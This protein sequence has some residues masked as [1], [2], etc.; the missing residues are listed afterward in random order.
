MKKIL[1]ILI[2]AMLSTNVVNASDVNKNQVI[3]SI[4]NAIVINDSNK[5]IR[6]KWK[7]EFN[8]TDGLLLEVKKLVTMMGYSFKL[9]KE[10]NVI[11]INIDPLSCINDHI[12]VLRGDKEDVKKE[13]DKDNKDKDNVEDEEE[14]K[15][16]N[17]E[18]S[19]DQNKDVTQKVTPVAVEIDIKPEHF[20]QL[21]S[22]PYTLDEITEDLKFAAEHYSLYY[23][24][25]S[26]RLYI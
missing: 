18:E 5:S 16:D 7:K 6:V 23:E 3:N 15:G 26:Y 22:T 17:E 24:L 21:D 12:N 1:L 13:D 20:V 11:I 2:I 8:E 10:N 14:Q 25:R 4:K 19:Q 9:D